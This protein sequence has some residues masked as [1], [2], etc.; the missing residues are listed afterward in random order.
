[1]RFPSRRPRDLVAFFALVVSLAVF[2]LQLRTLY[3]VPVF[4]SVRWG[5]DETWLMREFVHQAAHGVLLY[6]ESFG[7]PVRTNGV[8]AGSMWGDAL[9]YGV[10]GIIFFPQYDY[11]SIGRTVTAMLSLLL[12]GS[13]Y[14]IARSL[15]IDP[16][17]CSL[18]VGLMVMSQGFVWA[19]HSAR[20]DLLTGLVLVWYCYYLSK[21][22]K[23][24]F[25]QMFLAGA[26]GIITIC[27]S[28]H[29]LTL[30]GAATL[31]FF[32][33]NRVWQ[34]PTG[35]LAWLMGSVAG[36]LVLSI[37]YV[38]G[39][40]EFSLFG[41]GGKVGIFS[42][43]LNEIP[44]VRPFSRNVQ[45]SNLMERIHLFQ[46]DLPGML[47][48]LGMALLIML[49][50]LLR[51]HT[52]RISH[53]QGFFLMSTAFCSV[54]WLLMEGSR[55]YYLF[56][57]VPL[58]VIG[59]VIILESWREVFS[60]RW[61]GE[62]GAIVVL[63]IAVTLGMT[64]AIPSPALG[65]AVARDQQSAIS[66]FLSEAR[67]DSHRKERILLDVAGLDR[68]L[69]DTSC[70]I[71]TLDMFQPPANTEAL[72]RKLYSN[73]IDYVVLRSSPIGTPF[74][75]GRAL[76]PH[77]LDSIGDVQDSALGIFYD[78]GRSYD[79]SLST[80]LDGGLDTLKLYRVRPN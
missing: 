41:R 50:Y 70:E 5:G 32:I 28:P 45:V 69:A 38:I 54:S 71:L 3:T 22:E 20:Y 62:M 35:L 15:K 66:R 11:V 63:I 42:F 40:G 75:P 7:D 73:G 4:D 53:P 64:H 36:I 6:P 34:K 80:L 52:L 10:P 23:F 13:L 2:A 49:V 76:I 1:M 61:F 43:V 21:I 33:V 79:V 19:S 67:K 25:W 56:H 48:A 39:S 16:L 46:T 27:F 60:M 9:L 72:I 47:I 74:E 59:G 68:A 37:A 77:V 51:Q 31:A 55:P 29:L 78:D 24:G 14:F 18:A 26:I 12:I 57:I 17:L 8:L 58:L 65:E 30:A 44:I